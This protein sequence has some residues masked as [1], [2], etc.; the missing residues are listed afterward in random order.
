MQ[1]DKYTAIF[2][3][4]ENVYYHLRNNYADIPELSDFV[5]ELLMNL[6]KH[7]AEKSGLKSIVAKSYADYERI[8]ATPQGSLY[9]MG[10][11]TIYVL[12]STHKNSAD[13]KLSIDAVEVLHTRPEIDTFVLF[14]GDR[15]YIPLIQHLKKAAKS[16]IGVGF[17]S[18]FSGDLLTNI[19][20]D[21]FIE[22]STLFSDESV[23]KLELIAQRSRDYEKAEEERRS[24][25]IQELREQN[26][27]SEMPLEAKKQAFEEQSQSVEA[28]TLPDEVGGVGKPEK[29]ENES[30]ER[31]S[32]LEDAG[33]KE[34]GKPAVLEEERGGGSNIPITDLT[35]EERACL[36]LMVS[37]FGQYNEIFLSPFLRK[38]SDALPNLAD[39]QRKGLLGDLE[40]KGAVRIEKRSG[41][42]YD[43]SVVILNW[44]HPSVREMC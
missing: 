24:E 7:L 1:N 4:Y 3:D 12:G 38:L 34:V 16:V 31:I 40:F 15:D 43:Y 5:V 39:W 13:M 23:R 36:S 19:G 8:K 25:Q 28:D 26:D 35:E 10:V 17:A 42:P 11:E 21:N 27:S 32:K 33:G 20:K 18:S 14:A 44:N 37:K 22:A 9:L 30:D 29:G 2:V 41:I 6:Q